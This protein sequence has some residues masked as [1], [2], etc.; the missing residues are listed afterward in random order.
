MNK[1]EA[2]D[3]ERPPDCPNFG[4]MRTC[5][6]AYPTGCRN[7]VCRAGHNARVAKQTSPSKTPATRAKAL[8]NQKQFNRNDDSSNPNWAFHPCCGG[9]WRR[10]SFGCLPK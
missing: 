10:K 4:T 7:A 1:R 3:K 8:V 9:V 2:L 5:G 6:K